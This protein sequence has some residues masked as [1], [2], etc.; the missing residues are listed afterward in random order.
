MSGGGGGGTTRTEPPTYLEPHLEASANQ[1]GYLYGLGGPQQYP[2][3]TVVPFSQ[4]TEQA[5][6]GVQNRAL[7]GSPVNAAANQYMTDMLSGR[8][9]SPDSNPWLEQTYN[10][11]AQAT[12]SQLDSQFAGAGRDI[13]AQLPARADQ[14][15]NLATSIYG[16]A[17]D[18]ER[19]RQNAMLPFAP[20]IA[21]QDYFDWGQL[22][23]VGGQ[24]EGLASQYQGD[25][26]NRWMYEQM[27]PEQN[28]DNWI[29][30]LGL[31]PASGYGTQYQ[32]TDRNSLLGAAG[33][34]AGGAMLANALGAAA[35]GPW[36]W[37]AAG[38]G[39]LLGLM[40]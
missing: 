7:S 18:A 40:G 23:N 27:L 22:A 28:L 37:G 29:Q 25:A 13:E 20:Q 6:A 26:A 10:R 11:A 4:Q 31:N 32:D 21:N 3:S 9:L 34:A 14:L 12:R 17:Y 39:G 2:G 19:G 16:G 24:V 35:G 1:S 8:Y 38:L 5:M 15:N 30:R 33:G 36:M